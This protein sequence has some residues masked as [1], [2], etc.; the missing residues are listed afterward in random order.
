[1]QN[2]IIYNTANI[3]P[4]NTKLNKCKMNVKSDAN[5]VLLRL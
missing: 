5:N 2:N 1:M 4:T 3:G